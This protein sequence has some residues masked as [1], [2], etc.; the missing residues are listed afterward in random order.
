M[1]PRSRRV[2]KAEPQTI[3]IEIKKDISY[4]NLCKISKGFSKEK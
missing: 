3:Y 1:I 2:P 4:K